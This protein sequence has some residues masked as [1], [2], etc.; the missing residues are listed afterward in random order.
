LLSK[1]DNWTVSRTELTD[2]SPEARNAITSALRELREAGYAKLETK[3]EGSG[4]RAFRGRVWCIFE[5]PRSSTHEDPAS[6]RKSASYKVKIGEQS[7]EGKLARPRA[8]YQR[9]SF[10]LAKSGTMKGPTWDVVQEFA[11][12]S[13]E[14]RLHLRRKGSTKTGWS[15]TALRQWHMDLTELLDR[16]ESLRN[17][18]LSMR[19]YFDHYRE[20]YMPSCATLSGFCAKFDKVVDARKRMLKRKGEQDEDEEPTRTYRVEYED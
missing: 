15:L 5:K 16:V 9:S 13:V 4:D 1:P 17:I 11:N 6:S 19:W 18:Q 8:A 12:W 7:K 20:D 14:N 10:G 2:S 3:T